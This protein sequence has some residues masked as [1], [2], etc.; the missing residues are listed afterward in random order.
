M[1]RIPTKIWSHQSLTTGERYLSTDVRESKPRS[2]KIFDELVRDI[3]AISFNNP[4]HVLFFRGQTQDYFKKI[5][6]G[7]EQ[8]R[9]SSF[10]PTIYRSPGT[11]LTLEM[12]D[13]RRKILDRCASSLIQAFKTNVIEGSE[14]LGKFPEV[15]W[16]ILQHYDV[17]HTPLL[18]M[19][20]SLRVAA[21]F[22][23]NSDAANGYL[24]AFGFPH[25]NGSISYS[26]EDELLNV[27]LLSICPPVAT[28]PH[29]QEGFLVGSFPSMR[30]RRHP[31]LDLGVRLIAKFKLGR[32]GFWT[33]EFHAIPQ[34]AL[35]PT[36]DRMRAI[37]KDIS[38][39]V[40][41]M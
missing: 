31:N 23:L 12:L 13:R 41:R 33:R 15:A 20:H 34:G 25:P 40:D 21:S 14:K 28:R 1:K 22:A 8:R 39:S 6:T 27:R 5:K 16:A 37:C 32:P 11:P 2:V 29:F 4:E 3:A 9:V 30:E 7:S 19:T 24:F 10:Y 26:V 38:S 36:S 18:D 35:Y 17:C